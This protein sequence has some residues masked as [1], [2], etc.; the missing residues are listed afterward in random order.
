MTTIPDYILETVYLPLALILVWLAKI[1]KDI[2][3]PYNLQQELLER[4]NPAVAVSVGGYFLAV[5]IVLIGAYLGGSDS[6][7]IGMMK[8]TAFGALGIVLL[9]IAAKL[10][11]MFILPK[12]CNTRELVDDQNIGAGLVE[13]ATSIASGMVV[14]GAIN[15][16]GGGFVTAVV[17]FFLSQLLLVGIVQFYNFLT[18]MNIFKEIEEDN[19]AMGIAVAGNLIGAGVLIMRGTS[20]DFK[21]WSAHLL[22]FAIW[23]G[24]AALLLPVVR[25]F[26]DKVLITDAKL[27]IELALRRNQAVAIVEMIVTVTFAILVAFTFSFDV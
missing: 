5:V 27:D 3:A 1:A 4:K 26:I 6:L 11:D 24:I 8:F 2:T 18:P 25:V 23:A 22:H 14:A 15:G 16:E 17:F 10:N 19:I 9:R 20:G 12:M 21:G 7:A 13:F